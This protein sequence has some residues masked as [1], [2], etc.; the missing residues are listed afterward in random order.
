M[1]DL[2]K[3]QLISMLSQG[4]AMLLGMVETFLVI[5]ILNVGEWGLVQL[6]VSIGGALGIYQH[7]G[8]VSAS[9]REISS[10]KKDED[11]FKIFITSSVVRYFVTIPISVGLFFGAGKISQ[12]LYHTLDLILPLKIYAVALVFQ[13]VQ[14][15]LNSVIS[16]TKRFKHLFIYQVVI[17]FVN[18]LIFIP[19]V[20]FFKVPGYFYAFLTFNI[21]SSIS[22]A[23]IAFKPLKGKIVMPTKKE[24]KNLFKEIFSISIAIYVVKILYTN[25]EKLGNNLLVLSKSPEVVAMYAF[26][27]LYA[28]KLMTI[29]DS[30]TTVNI[31]VFSERFVNDF[32]EFKDSF[33]KNFN[34]IFSAI[35]LVGTFA[36]YFAPT[37]IRILVGGDKYDQAIPLI[38]PMVFAI[39]LYS[40][41]NIINSSVLIP[42]KMAKSMIGSYVFLIIGTGISYFIL[43]NMMN[44]SLAFSWSMVTGSALC[45]FFMIYWIKKRMKFLFFNLDHWVILIQSLSISLLCNVDS[46][47]VKIAGLIPFFGLLIWGLFEAGFIKKNDLKSLFGKFSLLIGKNKK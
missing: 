47:W 4:L 9:T 13:G 3:W 34:K 45:L 23:V 41:V 7:L 16:G 12:N 26:A 35:I 43:K 40:F 30:I 46:F 8:L 25:W 27:L 15:I 36:S 21:I 5:R 37:L 14:G 2:G 32:K 44:V 28:K 29:S 39:V 17:A 24:F 10:A 18:I 11:I 19:F 38:A 31:P 42:A 33:S 6:A 1:K 22:L 20:Y